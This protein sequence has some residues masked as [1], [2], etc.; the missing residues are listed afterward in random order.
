MIFLD[1]SFSPPEVKARCNELKREWGR[2]R[3]ERADKRGENSIDNSSKKPS[4]IR[5]GMRS[6]AQVEGTAKM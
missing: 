3:E 4:G 1:L 2:E 5:E 6:L